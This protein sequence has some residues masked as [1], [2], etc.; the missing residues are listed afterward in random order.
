MFNRRDLLTAAA[1]IL[2]WVPLA[3][4]IL[5]A[6]PDTADGPLHVY[7]LVALREAWRAG[8][9][10]PRFSP[11][12]FTGYGSALFN[13]YA[14][15]YLFPAAALNTLGLN[16]QTALWASLLG[17]ALV[18]QVGMFLLGRDLWS[19]ADTALVGA[20][21]FGHAPYI[22]FNL[23]GRGAAA[24]FAALMLAPWVLWAFHRLARDPRRRTLIAAVVAY[25]LF[26]PLHNITTLLVTVTL[27]VLCLVWALDHGVWLPLIGAGALAFGLTAFAWGPALLELGYVR[28]GAAGTNTLIAEG[29]LPLRAIVALPHT[30]DPTRL[31]QP[32]PVALGWVALLAGMG[33]VVLAT[34]DRERLP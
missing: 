34:R 33:G 32:L 21:A 8:D 15:L 10:W 24:E 29:F 19:R 3:T 2:L 6:V 23:M 12:L 18:G 20:A 17:Y 30:A 28:V 9:L 11:E 25:A 13:Y 27:M 7:R 4:V 31:R 22:L 5:A 26:I 1:L 16:A 14:P